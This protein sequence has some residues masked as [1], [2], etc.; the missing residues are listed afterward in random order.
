M[1]ELFNKSAVLKEIESINFLDAAKQMKVAVS[2]IEDCFKG[3]IED[4][5]CFVPTTTEAEI[6]AKALKDFVDWIDR[7]YET[8]HF[9]NECEG[10]KDIR[11]FHKEYIAEQLK[12]ES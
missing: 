12:E 4:R 9:I 6:R 7:N 10:Y 5:L 8:K 1:T 11:D 3:I 2:D